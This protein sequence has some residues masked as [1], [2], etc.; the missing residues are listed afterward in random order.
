MKKSL[1]IVLGVVIAIILLVGSS[2][3]SLVSAEEEVD[4]KL[5]NIS[6]QLERR[7]DLIPNLVNTVKGYAAHEKEVIDSVT[8]ARENLVNADT[9]G[10]MAEANKN[11][12]TAFFCNFKLRNCLYSFSLFFNFL[13]FHNFL[14]NKFPHHRILT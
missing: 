11:L 2:Y 14:L 12:T 4:G 8:S 10:E 3:N 13:F 7:A 9:A 5:S 6:V 1:I